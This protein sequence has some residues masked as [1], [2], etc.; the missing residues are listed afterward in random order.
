MTSLARM[1]ARNFG[2]SKNHLK[3]KFLA[4]IKAC[5]VTMYKV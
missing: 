1:P 2:L 4:C 3:P 5:V